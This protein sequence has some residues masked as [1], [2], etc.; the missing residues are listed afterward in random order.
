MRILFLDHPQFTAGSF[1]LWHGLKE[2]E[3]LSKGALQVELYP[4]LPTHFDADA[5]NVKDMKW[6]QDLEKVV[7]AGPGALPWGVP[8]FAP[9][10]VLTYD[11]Q[12]EI[13]RYAHSVRF[14]PPEHLPSEDEIVR[15]LKGNEFDLVILA[16]SHRVPTILL[17]R[18]KE[19]AGATNMP[20]VVYYDA[21]ERDELCEHWIHV[22]RPD[23]T[24]KQILT[25]EVR[26]K[27]LS[28]A[29]QNYTWKVFP[30][31]LCSILIDHKET[32][33]GRI[34]FGR[35]QDLDLDKM[36]EVFYHMGIT[37][38]ERQAVLDALDEVVHGLKLNR[39]GPATNPN[40]HLTL[41]K[42]R[43]AVTMRGSGRDTF[44]YWEIPLYK[45]AM[46][47]DGTMGCIHPY[48]FEHGKTALFWKNVPEL[49]YM[50]LDR[51]SGRQNAAEV[52]EIGIAGQKHLYRY[53]STMMRSIFFLDRVREFLRVGGDTAS[54]C[55]FAKELREWPSDG[56]WEGPVV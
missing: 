33:V 1:L 20:P 17:G 40:Y 8:P 46:L 51:I 19:R 9:G 30:L 49:I 31:P 37:W 7:A 29:V 22:F 13:R 16:N 26:A 52:Q 56:P 41:V 55:S 25:P 23:L 12:Q 45:T 32:M 43:M 5:F 35:I 50:V 2:V 53:H 38:P 42:S 28:A 27:G 47:S 18:L 11:G 36:F 15:R 39:V 54:V 10:E 14:K 3:L 6:Y 21:G 44:R 4:H 24:F 34:P 48:P